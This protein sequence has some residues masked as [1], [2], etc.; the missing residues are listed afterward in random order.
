MYF[1][2]KTTYQAISGTTGKIEKIT[3][4]YLVK[5]DRFAEAEKETTTALLP[6]VKGEFQID[7]ITR[8]KVAEIIDGIGDF[9][10][11]VKCIMIIFDEDSGKEKRVSVPYLIK[12]T[13]IKNAESGFRK[14]MSETLSDYEIAKIGI[15]KIVDVL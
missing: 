10:F 1:L 12:S 14:F 8:Y 3:D 2:T 11:D 6:F 15:T 4:Q 7:S 5:C 9:Y 13:D